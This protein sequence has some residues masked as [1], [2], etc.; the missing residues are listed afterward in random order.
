MRAP[1]ASEAKRPLEGSEDS[2]QPERPRSQRRMALE[3]A[4]E[5]AAAAAAAAEEET[6]RGAEDSEPEEAPES[7]QPEKKA[8][9]V[10]TRELHSRFEKAV[11]QL[12]VAQAKPQA[13]Q[14]LMGCASDDEPPTRQNIKSHLQ[15]YRLLLQKQAAQQAP[16]EHNHGPMGGAAD[17][18]GSGGSGG[19]AIAGGAG[20]VRSDA[21]RSAIDLL[22]H[23][24][25]AGLISQ[26][27]LH[28]SLQETLLQQRQTQAAIGWK[29]A[30]AG[31][32]SVLRHEQLQRMAEHVLMQRQMLH[33]LCTMLQAS[34]VEYASSAAVGLAQHSR[35]VPQASLRAPHAAMPLPLQPQQQQLSQMHQQHSPSAL[36]MQTQPPV[37]TVQQLPAQM[38]GMGN[39]PSAPAVALGVGGGA[40]PLGDGLE[41]GMG[42]SSSIFD[43]AFAPDDETSMQ[44]LLPSLDPLLE[45]GTH[46]DVHSTPLTNDVMAPVDVRHTP[47]D[48]L[49]IGAPSPAEA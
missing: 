27:E 45:V 11:H 5:S 31:A 36:P 9:F 32:S 18:S 3:A 48:V 2:P 10:W 23:Q 30:S 46:M 47:S 33:H 42:S 49:C 44:G 37:A 22:L 41:G 6:A 8:R 43:G 34:T 16:A 29:L 35:E 28:A 38:L 17:T 13:I 20:G 39:F 14:Q 25:Q 4:R 7:E 12:G 24:Q 40:K 19:G 26:L 15:K 1:N 21:K